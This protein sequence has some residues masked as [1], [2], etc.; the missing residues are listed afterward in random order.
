MV[1]TQIYDFTLQLSYYQ[2]GGLS[3]SCK[4]S[5]IQVDTKSFLMFPSITLVLIFKLFWFLAVSVVVGILSPIIPFFAKM[6]DVL[7]WFY[8][9]SFC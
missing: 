5:N 8:A 4:K 6:I 7:C 1:I 9:F 3:F 2:G